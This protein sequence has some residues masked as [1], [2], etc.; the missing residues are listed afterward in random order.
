VVLQF[1]VRLATA[2]SLVVLQAKRWILS[3]GHLGGLTMNSAS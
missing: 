1:N 3:A 2:A